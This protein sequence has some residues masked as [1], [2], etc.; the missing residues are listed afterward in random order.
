MIA[1]QEYDLLLK[2]GMFW[3][4]HPNLTGEW[5]K[6]RLEWLEIKGIIFK[7]STIAEKLKAI[8]D[9]QTQEE[10]QSEWDEIKYL[11]L[12]GPTVEEYFGG[13][14][15]DNQIIYEAMYNPCIYES[16]YMI[17]SLHKTRKGAEIA[18][19][20]HKNEVKKEFDD[21]YNDPEYPCDFIVDMQWDDN[22]SWMIQETILEE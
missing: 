19:Q 2:S 15:F 22:Q 13:P 12:I 16:S 14:S 18:I 5:K 3:E 17:L 9:N 20:N 21:M 8:F 11:D 7:T 1:R 4:F 6:D 10:T